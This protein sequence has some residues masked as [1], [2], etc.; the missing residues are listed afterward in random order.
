MAPVV[1]RSCSCL[2]E[3][4]SCRIVSANVAADTE[5][6]SFTELNKCT[7]GSATREYCELLALLQALLGD[8]IF[9]QII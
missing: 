4:E 1:D 6:G 9:G 7:M 8:N 2:S 5:G 3:A